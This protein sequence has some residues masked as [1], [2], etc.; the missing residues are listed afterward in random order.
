M[1]LNGNPLDLH[2]SLH[3]LPLAEGATISVGGPQAS[4][5]LQ[6]LP[7]LELRI[8]GGEAAGWTFP[9][10]DG[11]F[12]LGRDNSADLV[13]PD[14]EVSQRHAELAVAA[15][16]SMQLRDL[17]STNGTSVEGTPVT[18][19][20]ELGRGDLIQ[21][22]GTTI[23][24]DAPS[25]ECLPTVADGTR[26]Q[27]NRRFRLADPTWPDEVRF[28]TEPAPSEAPS[29][30]LLLTLLPA[31][32]IG[33]VALVSGRTEFLLFAAMSPL[34]GITR[35]VLQRRTWKRTNARDLV[36]YEQQYQ[37]AQADL[38]GAAREER[39][40]RRVRDP[41]LAELDR[42][43]RLPGRRLW[44]RRPTDSDFLRLRVG[45][46]STATT[47]A[48]V[49]REQQALPTLP[50][51]PV[52]VDLATTGNLSL[53]GP[54]ERGRRVA[55]G[56]VAQL[57]VRESP[58]ALKTIVVAE[59]SQA[60]EWEWMS[61]LPHCRWSTD[62]TYALVG[63][64]E[65]SRRSRLEEVR[66][67]LKS[68]LEAA[69]NRRDLQPPLP[70]VVI[71]L[72]NATK[73]LAEGWAEVLNDGPRVGI[74]AICIDETQVPSQCEA[75]V[76]I[77]TRSSD[78]GELEQRERANQSGLLVD[79][80]VGTYLD[81]LARSLAPL[82]AANDDGAQLELPSNL[83]L[84]D[85]V[86]GDV[87]DG[88][89]VSARWAQSSPSPSA[90]VGLSADGAFSLD[91]T[92]HGP[93]GLVAGTTRAGKSEFIKTL[94]AGF[95]LVN[96]P[97]DLSF[98]F[99]D[100]KGGADYRILKDLPHAVDL[101]TSEDLEEFERT[102]KL[103]EAEIGRRRAL[104]AVAQ[105]NTIEGY[106]TARSTRRDLPPIPRLLV[107]ADEFAELVSLAPKQLEKLVSVARTGA[108][109]GIHLLLATQRPAGA[110]TPQ[111]DAN[112]ALRV[113]FRVKSADES[114][115]VIDDP[116]AGAIAQRHRGR[117]FV[118]AHQEPLI[119]FQ[120]ARVG[121]AR[122]GSNVDRE[123]LAVDLLLWSELGRTRSEE[124]PPKEVP[125]PETDLWD[126]KE[127]CIA[128]ARSVG[129]SSNAVPWPKPLPD[130]VQLDQLPDLPEDSLVIPF[131]L[132]D[133][134][135]TQSHVCAG[136]T[137]GGGHLGLAGSAGTGR[138][139]ALRSLACA[140]ATR[141]EPSDLHIYMLDFGGGGLRPIADLPHCGGA[142]FE[143]WEQA[144]RIVKGLSEMVTSRLERFGD[145]GYAGILDQRAN[146][147]E[148]MPFVVLL[149]DGWDVI[150]EEGSRYGL[151]DAI[152]QVLARGQS[153]GLQ[154][155]IAG[156]RSVAMSRI[157]R[158]LSEKWALRLNRDTD[159]GT[160]GLSN[161]DI[162]AHQ[163]PGRVVV[164]STAQEAQIAE[165]PDPDG[166][167]QS[168]AIRALV[169]A[170]RARFA[171]GDSGLRRI[172]QLPRSI[173]LEKVVARGAPPPDAEVPVLFG[174]D[175]DT[176][177]PIWVDL[178]LSPSNAF[179]VGPARSGRSTALRSM[180]AA[181]LSRGIAIAL[182]SPRLSPLLDLRDHDGVVATIDAV[183]AQAFEAADVNGARVV[184]I[185]DADA[186]SEDHRGMPSLLADDHIAVVAAGSLEIFS[187]SVKGWMGAVKRSKTGL[188]LS[189]RNK[190]DGAFFGGT[191]P[192]PMV[193]QGPPGRAVAGVRGQLSMVQLPT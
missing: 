108:A 89:S 144:A 90:I 103:L 138:T 159:Y 19:W 85:V 54:I 193:F 20:V 113:C 91:L 61:W 169:D 13:I 17:G 112:V 25:I 62:D 82:V 98:L 3:D 58:A 9:L 111:I 187:D 80:P 133:D 47:V 164:V 110:V 59:S 104:F 137:L 167:G 130:A 28:P 126:V 40:A 166:I 134:P 70:A 114:V 30:N 170:Q 145:Q 141:R 74:H 101:S 148:P 71:V 34:V 127:A 120:A 29:L 76:R 105:S 7:A 139:S 35:A 185:D 49:G 143:E 33:I 79:L 10:V 97:D 168:G 15:D 63:S 11:S 88:S 156:D 45:A 41:D 24:V 42:H 37:Q 93:H 51:I 173:S 38:A 115:S 155:V 106:Q 131:A 102:V 188:V 67:L 152:A 177:V 57:A 181:L 154:G 142:A 190:Y 151:P 118:R 18:G 136:L 44:E 176:G 95:A 5:Q 175:G 92:I 146:D 135:E 182:V 39:D 186:L 125:D 122:K 78:S 6:R 69:N 22:G 150:D 100:F 99:I 161:R 132:L 157:G 109:F 23:V 191:F 165:V 107:V 160:L 124:G 56:Y 77:P 1:F 43:A 8:T 116:A 68:R 117:G 171:D 60:D 162:P 66:K 53:V 72:D 183:A 172:E 189:P 81:R 87:L 123:E 4:P 180:A 83:R 163:G 27:V 86:D 184:L 179:V 75:A 129:W 94:V 48:V 52:V 55:A 147:R 65:L 121:G 73:A 140:L 158:L 50:G 14:A 64:D 36:A 119:E 2:G 96:H 149:I 32:G 12:T 192:E 174:M 46:R 84:L 178:G 153:A 21:I 31:A 26:R 16:G 128:A